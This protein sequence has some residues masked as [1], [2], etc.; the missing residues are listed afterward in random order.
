MAKKR[1]LRAQRLGTIINVTSKRQ[2]QA[3][4]KAMLEVCDQLL[5]KFPGIKL[6]HEAQWLLPAVVADLKRKFPE[7][8][9]HHY[10]N[11]S[12]MRP[13]GG[14]LAIESNRG[15]TYPILIAEE[16][17]R[18]ASDAVAPTKPRCSPGWPKREA[19]NKR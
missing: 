7:V 19:I 17:N 12:A 2:E 4:T 14:I 3:L 8:D 15:P 18:T 13:D 16:R 10:H 9:F 1:D 11:T 6:K 5:K